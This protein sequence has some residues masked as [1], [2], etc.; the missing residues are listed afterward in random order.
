MLDLFL[1]LGVPILTTVVGILIEKYAPD[2][3][4]KFKIGT[5]SKN[6]EFLDV[7]NKSKDLNKDLL[8]YAKEKGLNYVV[9]QMEKYLK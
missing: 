1:Y 2:S 3:L 9:K 4:G 6:Q 5:S 7:I 8:D